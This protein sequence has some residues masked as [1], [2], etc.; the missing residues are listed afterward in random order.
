MKALDKKKAQLLKNQTTTARWFG[1]GM[2]ATSR[3]I[4]G[5]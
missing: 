4:L 2:A 5:H 3:L 1:F